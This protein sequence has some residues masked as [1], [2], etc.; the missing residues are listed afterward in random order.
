M[1]KERSRLYRFGLIAALIC[2]AA[3]VAPARTSSTDVHG[4][5]D[6]ALV[7]RMLVRH[8]SDGAV[9][10]VFP[11]GPVLLRS[12]RLAGDSVT[13][14]TT[15]RHFAL[16]PNRP[17]PFAWFTTISYS[18]ASD[19][20]VELTVYDFFYRKVQIVVSKD[21]PAGRYSV[22]WPNNETTQNPPSGMYFCTL[23]TNGGVEQLRMLLMK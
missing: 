22:T 19:S 20:H 4:A 21:Q 5:V 16:E 11:S 12:S 3:S 10:T 17:N 14:D 18:L 6:A 7:D 1:N 13:F 23:V 8:G 2:A 15:S 9:S